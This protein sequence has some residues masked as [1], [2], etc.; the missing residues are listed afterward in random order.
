MFFIVFASCVTSTLEVSG[1][2]C[3]TQLTLTVC[4]WIWTIS[5]RV[6]LVTKVIVFV[7]FRGVNTYLSDGWNILD[8]IIVLFSWTSLILK[9]SWLGAFW[10]FKYF[11]AVACMSCVKTRVNSLLHAI[12]G[13]LNVVLFTS[14]VFL[15]FGIICVVFFYGHFFLFF[16]WM[17]F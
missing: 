1:L 10:A 15:M 7:F 6:G 9:T 8:A 14:L 12:P 13:I 5:V 2:D 4:D 11:R 16:V 3:K 17:W